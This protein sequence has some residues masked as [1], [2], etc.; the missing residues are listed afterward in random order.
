VPAARGDIQ[1]RAA[2]VIVGAVEPPGP[3]DGEPCR[4]SSIIIT[5][6]ITTTITTITT[7]IISLGAG[8][9]GR[10]GNVLVIVAEIG[11]HEF[12]DPLRAAVTTRKRSVHGDPRDTHREEHLDR[13][14][15][16]ARP[17][18]VVNQREP[19][20]VDVVGPRDPGVQ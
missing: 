2:V 8:S 1:R 12:R 15:H 6:T 19:T 14:R 4:G 11:V 18:N 10:P 5:I 20:F 3:Q 17:R 9:S 7:T 16:V 13:G